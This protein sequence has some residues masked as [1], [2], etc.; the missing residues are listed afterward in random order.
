MQVQVYSRFDEIP[1]QCRPLFDAV[2]AE[3]GVFFSYPWFENLA[4]HGLPAGRLRIYVVSDEGVPQLIF[5]AFTPI[6][7]NGR[8]SRA[9]GACANYY[10]SL[11]GLVASSSPEQ[12]SQACSA[13]AATLVAE[14]PRWTQIDI[15]P[16][17]A[18]DETVAD[19]MRGLASD[20]GYVQDYYCFGNW[21]LEVAGRSYREYY[22]TLPS[23]LRNTVER[24]RKQWQVLPGARLEVFEGGEGLEEAIAAYV[25]VY[26]KSWKS[27][28]PRTE[29]MPGL[30]RTCAA[31]GWLRLG[32]AYIG[33]QAIAAQLWI[34]CA[35][36]ASIYKLAY[37]E[38][39]RSLSIGS[40]LTAH[41]M[42][43]AIDIDKVRMVDYLT[44]DD[45]YKRD[46][47]SHR[48]ERRGMIAYNLATVEGAGSALRSILGRTLKRLRGPRVSNQA[49]T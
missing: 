6:D 8:M 20:R 19:L 27:P 2:R 4:L 33:D 9:W 29:F 12:A 30:I 13:L 11:F 22:A 26:A 7:T 44:G 18:N 35:G 3:H 45:A 16:I 32:L 48:R 28:E 17:A 36:V 31:Q 37:D 15:Q 42:E 10:S 23:K 47:M 43:R 39:H 5:P 49:G 34:V 38:A 24:K 14:R 1:A 21:Y 41:M 46:W 40:I 25:G